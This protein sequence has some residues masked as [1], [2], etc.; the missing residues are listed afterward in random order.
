MSDAVVVVSGSQ[1][2]RLYLFC[3]VR[4]RFVF[5]RDELLRV[6]LTSPHLVWRRVNQKKKKGEK[7]IEN[8]TA[9]SSTRFWE[10]RRKKERRRKFFLSFFLRLHFIYLE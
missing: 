10:K 5:D 6:F 1:A 9:S 7:R 3:L 8:A 2:G 4:N